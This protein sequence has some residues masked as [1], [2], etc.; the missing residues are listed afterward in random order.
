MKI[1]DPGKWPF[2]GLGHSHDVKCGMWCLALGHPLGYRPGRPP[3]VR[4]GRVL[5]SSK[6]WFRPIAR[7]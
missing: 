7:W 6:A 3:V 5:A 4:V 1:T 2:V